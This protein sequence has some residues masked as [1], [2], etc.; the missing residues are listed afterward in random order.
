MLAVPLIPVYASGTA[1][2]RPDPG[3][4]R[5]SRSSGTSPEKETAEQAEPSADPAAPGSTF[6]FGYAEI[7]AGLTA[8]RDTDKSSAFG[9]FSEGGAAYGEPASA[10]WVKLV[11]ISA[12]AQEVAEAYVPAAVISEMHAL[13]ADALRSRLNQY[14]PVYYRGYPL[15]TVRLDLFSDAHEPDSQTPENGPQDP[16]RE[17]LPKG[18]LPEQDFGEE[19][20]QEELPVENAEEELPR[21]ILPEQDTEEAIP[22]EELREENAEEE[23]PKGILPEQDTQ[24]TEEAIPQEELQEKNAEEVLPEG[25]LPEEN[26]EEELPQERLPEEKPQEEAPDETSLRQEDLPSEEESG[27]RTEP[28]V[29]WQTAVTDLAVRQTG[30]NQALITWRGNGTAGRYSVFLVQA[31][32]SQTFLGFAE[33]A[34]SYTTPGLPD[35]DHSFVVLPCRTDGADVRTGEPSQPVRV[36][37][38]TVSWETAP[39]RA[40]AEINGRDVT[41]SWEGNG[42]AEQYTVYMSRDKSPMTFAGKTENGENELTLTDLPDGHYLF[43]IRP[44][45]VIND[46]VRH[47][48][49]SE[50]VRAVLPVVFWSTAVQDLKAAVTADGRADVVLTWSGNG[51]A[52]HYE[53][54]E[55]TEDGGVPVAQVSHAITC[56]LPGVTAGTHSYFV[57]PSRTVRGETELGDVSET[58]TID[59]S[60][61]WKTV[62]RNLSSASNGQSITLSWT[63]CRL[64]ESW[65]VFEQTPDGLQLLR[66]TDSQ[67][68]TIDNP[69][70]GGHVYLVYPAR[71][72]ED[73]ELG[74]PSDELFAVSGSHRAFGRTENGLVWTL[75]DDGTLSVYGSGQ[76]EDFDPETPVPWAE[77]LETVSAVRVGPGLTAIGS[78]AFENCHWLSAA[79][80]P[81]GLQ[82]IGDSAFRNCSAL[83]SVSFP[84]TLTDIRTGAFSSSGLVTADLPEGLA[85][86]GDGA[87]SGCAALTAVTLPDRIPYI[88]EYAFADCPSLA[89]LVSY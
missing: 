29:P 63:G 78:H 17:E 52:A 24:D 85:S 73:P 60:D 5:K 15:P 2:S 62:P 64:T 22:Q 20:S 61:L 30:A 25:I 44:R 23:L 28:E 55:A 87:F 41:L 56:I 18:I 67:E 82:V 57:R 14:H 11:F 38:R 76:M 42:V 37:I 3:I 27:S 51:K 72:K 49:P 47:G 50:P 84:E 9:V 74:E 31:D 33:G 77:Y 48:D 32:G 46:I 75:D 83:V 69:G 16:A 58:V 68:A 71:G 53:V 12:S 4:I 70:S 81:D 45:R 43:R 66:L 7:P 10:G 13:A 59:L 40:K 35:G 39:T 19:P 54:F 86:I 80:L 88:G 79:F 8:Y 34:E 21:G 65:A 26:A 1:G 6:P 89:R 36:T